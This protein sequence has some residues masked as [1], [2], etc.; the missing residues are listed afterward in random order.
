MEL[1]DNAESSRFDHRRIKYFKIVTALKL[2][3]L[4]GR[5]RVKVKK[6]AQA[7]KFYQVRRSSGGPRSTLVATLA[8]IES[9]GGR[10]GRVRR[11]VEA[12]F[13]LEAHALDKDGADLAP[14]RR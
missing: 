4:R 9:G 1:N 6:D 3:K 10:P 11:V 2:R 5:I 12:F 8:A 7:V 14:L 13:E